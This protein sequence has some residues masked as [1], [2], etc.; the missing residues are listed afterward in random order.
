MVGMALLLAMAILVAL[1]DLFSPD[2][3]EIKPDPIVGEHV[4][5][6]VAVIYA[7][8]YPILATGGTFLIKYVN[9]KVKIESIDFAVSFSFIYSIGALIAAIVHWTNKPE[10][11]VIHYFI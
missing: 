6:Y 8:I 2:A 7:F 1:S 5:V 11:F 3:E 4:P 10:T 9:K